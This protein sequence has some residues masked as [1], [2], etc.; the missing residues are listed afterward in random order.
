M[1][2]LLFILLAFFL[3]SGL[4]AREVCTM[5]SPVFE[6]TDNGKGKEVGYIEIKKLQDGISIHVVASGLKPGKYGFHMH[7]NNKMTNTID[8]DGNKVVGGGL[9]GH[10]DPDHTGRHAGPD[11]NGHRGDLEMVVA[12]A[13]GQVNQVIV[14]KRIPYDAVKGKSFVIHAMSDNYTD[15]PVNGGSGARMYAAVF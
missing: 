7:E 5:K 11:G 15:H 2:K 9:G 8:A 3:L 14:T 12:D 13:Q 6:L 10:W 4:Q 1:R